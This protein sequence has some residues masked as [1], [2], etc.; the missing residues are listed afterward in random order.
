MPRHPDTSQRIVTAASRLFYKHGIRAVGLDAVAAEANVTKRT[1]YYHFASK[2]DLIA[3]YLAERDQPSLALFAKWFDEK[4]GPLPSKVE[5]IFLNL[6]I[7]ARHPKWKGCGFLRTTAE[8][9][10][11][12]GHPAIKIGAQHK[13]KFEF[14]M[15]S[16][17]KEHGCSEPAALARQLL[18][19]LD[20]AFSTMLLHRDA[21]YIDQAGAA[22]TLVSVHLLK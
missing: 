12:P 16:K 22:A 18:V 14:W 11:L 8:L 10:N 6:S 17:M 1:I 9:A 2:D 13:K 20:G 5:A 3:A 7:A 15:E 19:L 4:R 21:D